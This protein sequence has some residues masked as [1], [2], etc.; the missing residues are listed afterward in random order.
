MTASEFF[1]FTA[2][3]LYEWLALIGATTVICGSAVWIHRRDRH[4]NNT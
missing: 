1:I 2:L 4:R 3:N